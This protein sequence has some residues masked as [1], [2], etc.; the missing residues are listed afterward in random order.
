MSIIKERILFNNSGATIT[1]GLSGGI[2]ISGYQQEIDGITEET[3]DALVNPIIDNEVRRFH[4]DN[5]M[6]YMDL[7]FFFTPDN[8]NYDDT[9]TT[10]GAGFS[11]YE[12]ESYSDNLRNSFFILEFYDSFDSYTQT[13]LFTSYLTKS[14]GG[15]TDTASPYLQI[16]AYRIYSDT[17]N[18]Y[19]NW[20]IPKSYTDTLTGTTVTGYVKFSFYNAKYGFVSLFYNKD[21]DSLSTPEKMYFKTTLDLTNRTWKFSDLDDPQEANAYEVTKNSAYVD[22]V[23]DTFDNYQNEQQS[24]PLG[25]VFTDDGTYVDNEGN[26]LYEARPGTRVIRTPTTTST[27]PRTAT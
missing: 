5:S 6:G 22:K 21:N 10:D 7:S 19:Y 26:V 2:S 11:D 24:Y 12:I 20:N 18:Q 3:K 1:F 8:S 23:N 27:T 4:Y 17:V 25:T 13:K 16:P 9:F 15:K 14:L